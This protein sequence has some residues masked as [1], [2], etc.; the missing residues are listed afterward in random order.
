LIELFAAGGV[1]PVEESGLADQSPHGFGI[2]HAGQLDHDAVRSLGRHD[3]LG[4]A[5]AIHA[6]FDDVA[7]DVHGR[8]IG[9]P[10]AGRLSLVLDPQPALEVEAEF[11]FDGPGPPAAEIG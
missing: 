3:G 7:D 10:S 8:R 2:R 9:R 4:H 1:A 6:A 5:R 11:R